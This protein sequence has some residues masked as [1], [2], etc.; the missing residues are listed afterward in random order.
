M[1]TLRTFI[2]T[3]AKYKSIVLFVPKETIEPTSFF[4]PLPFFALVRL[5]RF[6]SL[7]L[8]TMW[9]VLHFNVILLLRHRTPFILASFIRS[10]RT[11]RH[12][13][14]QKDT[15]SDKHVEGRQQKARTTYRWPEVLRHNTWAFYDCSSAYYYRCAPR[16]ST[17]RSA[18]PSIRMFVLFFHTQWL[19][20]NTSFMS[21]IRL[22]CYNLFFQRNFNKK[23]TA[24]CAEV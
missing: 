14:V 22:R 11:I 19:T 21:K 1:R 3:Y 5:F 20:T 17:G 18:S 15:F 9:K 23:K 7:L 4:H 10:I 12:F 13:G 24:K 16:F 8:L 2:N 6:P